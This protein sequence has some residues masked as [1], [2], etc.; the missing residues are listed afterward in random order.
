MDNTRPI[1]PRKV[2][3]K[4]KKIVTIIAIAK[5]LYPSE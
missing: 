1:N 2:L 3:R 4:Y 5:N